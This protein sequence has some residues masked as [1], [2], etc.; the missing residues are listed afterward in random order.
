MPDRILTTTL[1]CLLFLP[2]LS[3][4]QIGFTPT[5]DP[6]DF[7]HRLEEATKKIHSIESNFV[8]EKN[9]SALS[10]KITSKG[11]FIFQKEKSLRWEYT[12]PYQYLIILHNDKFLVRDDAKVSKF[13]VQS[14]KVFREINTIIL[15]CVQ[16]TLLQD[17]KRFSAVY[18]E[19]QNYY[20][21]KLKPLTSPMRE[22]L[23]E[24]R[25]YFDKQDLTVSKLEMQEVSGDYTNIAFTQ[26]KF[27]MTYP[28]E[29][30]NIK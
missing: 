24:I 15:G 21:V 29:K 7:R 30:F 27:N 25:I 16:G 18:L 2:F 19:N 22:S 9:M 1:L 14:N 11:K 5:A 17:T 28:D 13:D 4:T 8:Q 23:S 10:E 12:E 26:K 3:F 20:L 6:A